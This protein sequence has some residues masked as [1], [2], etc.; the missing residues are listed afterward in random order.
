MHQIVLLPLKQQNKER[1]KKWSSAEKKGFLSK[2]YPASLI[3]VASLVTKHRE[4][5][6]GKR[7]K[8]H[9]PNPITILLLLLNIMPL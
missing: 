8:L 2:G 3:A 9:I 6:R 5:K 1:R 4:Y 7:P